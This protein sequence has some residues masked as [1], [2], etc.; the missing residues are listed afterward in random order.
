MNLF[1]RRPLRL[2]AVLGC[3]IAGGALLG[4]GNR[5]TD[6]STPQEV[7]LI[8]RDMAFR[9]PA[10]PGRANP[11]L[12]LSEGRPVRLVLKNEE[13]GQVLHCFTIAGL[14]VHTS[15]NLEAG[16]AE[17]ITFTPQESG[18]FTYACLMHPTMV[19][20]VVVQ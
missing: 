6:A 13:P 10:E 1:R 18:L 5:S 12:R 7:V 9:T 19:G 15:R 14:G 8:A 11:Q 17:E 20:S 16:E 4:F 3:I 2:L